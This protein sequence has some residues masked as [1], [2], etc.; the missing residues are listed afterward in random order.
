MECVRDTACVL[1]ASARARP[2]GRGRAG[3]VCLG[4]AHALV[5]CPSAGWRKLVGGFRWAWLQ[6]LLIN[7]HRRLP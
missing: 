3:G 5:L 1:C 6:L 4:H 2:E 7:T